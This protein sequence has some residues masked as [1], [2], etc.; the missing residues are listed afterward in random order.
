MQKIWKEQTKTPGTNRQ[1]IKVAG[2]K[3]NIQKSIAFLYPSN[4]QMEF[5][6]KNIIPLTSTPS[7][8]KQLSINLTK[9]VQDLYKENYKTLINEIKSQ[10][11][12]PSQKLTQNE[13]QIQM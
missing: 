6:V 8:V 2:Q 10:N 4:E 5:E 3:N 12:Q 1:F 7:K 11:L 9:F 13:S